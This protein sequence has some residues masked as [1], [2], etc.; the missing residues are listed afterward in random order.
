MQRKTK[1]SYFSRRLCDWP[2]ILIGLSVSWTCAQAADKAT[3]KSA[4]QPAC[5]RGAVGS[6][7]EDA[8]DRVSKNGLLE[9][10]LK[11]RS[12]MDENGNPRYCYIDENGNRAPT[13]RVQPG[14]T[15]VVHLKNEISL[16]AAPGA[17]S[18]PVKTGNQRRN[19]CDGGEM[20]AAS[21]N[22]HFHGLAIPPVC[23]QD[24]TLKT[25]IQPG[26]PPFEYRVQIPKS[27]PPGLYWYHPHV[28]G[29][30][31]EQLLGGAS[32]ALVVEGTSR[33][34]SQLAG[35]PER[36]LVI[37]DE[38]MPSL[39][40]GDKPDPNRPTKQISIN[41]IPVPYPSYPTP[42]IKMKP[43]ERQYWRVLNA[44]ADT[45]INLALEYD[46]KRQSVGLVSLDGVPLRFGEPDSDAYVPEQTDVF[47]SPGGRAEF[48]VTAPPEGVT[49]R[50]VTFSMYRGADEDGKPAA[51][52]AGDAPAARI[53]QDDNDPFRPLATIVAS[54]D[55]GGTRISERSSGQ[56]PEMEFQPLSSVRP[57]RKR[58]L[59]FSEKLVN[60]SDP[61]SATH[62]FITEEG[63][64]EK[65]FDPT[66]EPNITVH[67]G[68]VEDWTI[69][70]RSREVHTFHIHQ[71]HFLVVNRRGTSWEEPSLRDT[72]NLAAWSGFGQ[73][74]SLT[75]R[76]DFRDPRIVG[77][78]PF[79]CHIMQHL[80]GGMMG[81]VKVEAEK[82]TE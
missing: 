2:L 55:A 57:T 22:L 68:E 23:H 61:K 35:L 15:L 59:Y 20:S 16:P 5:P 9:I 79:H 74:P 72:V 54:V 3:P 6:I 48:I 13:L 58:T 73:Y 27:Q 12:S 60:P 49:G 82:K 62:F 42:V 71:L 8:H 25:V 45:Y 28:H 36:V 77:T 66:S 1:I 39:A 50:L 17:H 52:R 34:V 43:G 4:P 26:D 19:P 10:T 67:Q 44:S 76:M 69:E 51:R 78:F 31:E 21:M 75:V 38:K 63:H 24:E 80:D 47:V 81:T 46:G 64:T 70:N 56:A 32:G 18:H 7:V 41:N 33:R 29:F 14:D 37:R 65:A 53:G 30:S 11:V 40:A